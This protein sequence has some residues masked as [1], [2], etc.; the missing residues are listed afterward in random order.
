MLFPFVLFYI[1]CIFEVENDIDMKSEIKK[2]AFFASLLLA[3]S[4]LGAQSPLTENGVCINEVMQSTFGGELD[5]LMEY[6]DSWVELYNPSSGTRR[7]KGFKI[8][9]K[10][11]ARYNDKTDAH[12]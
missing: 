7:L 6:P 11:R 5:M 12:F 4:Q 3:C 10:E 8:G 2:S 9:K 1:I